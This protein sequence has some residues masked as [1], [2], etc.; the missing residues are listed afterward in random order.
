MIPGEIIVIDDG[1]RDGTVGIAQT[2]PGVKVIR[3]TGVHGKGAALR[4]GL[5]QAAGEVVLIQD[6]DLE[7]DPTD[8][9]FLL[10]PILQGEASVVYGSR[11][12]GARQGRSRQKSSL[13]Y[14]WGGR[15]LS[16]LTSF[17]YGVKITDMPTGYK[18]FKTDVLKSVLWTADGF[19]FCPEV[20]A[21]ILRKR[22]PI[23]EVPIAYTPRSFAE[24]K[25]IRWKD[26][27]IAIR[28]LIAFRWAKGL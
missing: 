26:G 23:V 1:S 20:T 12:L 28:T 13:R 17:L 19:E 10:K 18:V 22:I 9:P 16:W 11:I 24:G 25:K 7:Y 15:F 14:Y 3:Q 4:T 21:R 2:V 8:Y 5:A 27:W 6:A